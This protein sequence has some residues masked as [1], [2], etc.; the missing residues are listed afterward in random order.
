[1]AFGCRGGH[2]ARAAIGVAPLPA[3]GPA[4][5]RGPFSRDHLNRCRCPAWDSDGH[6]RR[7][8]PGGCRLRCAVVAI[9]PPRSCT[10]PPAPPLPPPCAAR[11]PGATVAHEPQLPAP[12][13]AVHRP[14]PPGALQPRPRVPPGPSSGG[15]GMTDRIPL[16]GQLAFNAVEAFLPNFQPFQ[17]PLGCAALCF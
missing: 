14:P 10:A 7:H 5:G 11:L 1:M 6:R 4:Q 8:C 15:G 2:Q 3:P 13:L 17:S 9:E 12:Q 16:Q